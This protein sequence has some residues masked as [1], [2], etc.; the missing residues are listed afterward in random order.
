MANLGRWIAERSELFGGSA[1]LDW[2]K[3]SLPA[4]AGLAVIP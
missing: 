3:G 1:M 4:R 2:F